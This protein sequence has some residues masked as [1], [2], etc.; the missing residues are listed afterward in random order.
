MKKV[1]TLIAASLCCASAL[2]QWSAPMPNKIQEM[3][4]DGT[5]QFLYNKGAGGFFTGGNEYGTRASI[6]AIGDSVRMTMITNTNYNFGDYPAT[7][8]AWYYLS[9]NNF[10]TMWIDAPN[11]SSNDTYPNTD[12]WNV[13]PQSDGSYKFVNNGYDANYTLGVAEIFNGKKGNTRLYIHD[14]EQTYVV[15]EEFKMSFEGNFYDT[16]Y[17][18]DE[19]EYLSLQP[20]VELYTTAIGLKN[21]IDNAK[22]EGIE[23]DFSKLEAVYNNTSSSIEEL[24]AA[25]ATTN[26]VV[27]FINTYNS[28][29]ASYPTANLSALKAICDNTASTAEEI[30]AAETMLL[31]E[32]LQQI[33]GN[34]TI[35]NP[36][37]FSATIGDG[38]TTSM[39][40]HSW[41]GVSTNGTWQTNTSSKEAVD[42]ADGTDMTPSFCELKIG[43]GSLVSDCF[44]TQELK[45]L[46]A[47][48]Y[49]FTADVRLYREAGKITAFKGAKMFF[50][51]DTIA[52]QD[53]SSVTYSGTKSILW[54]KDY[55]SVIAVVK[56]SGDITLGFDIQACNYNWFAFKNTT[57]QYYGNENIEKNALKLFKKSVNL[58]TLDEVDAQEDLISAYN[59]AVAEYNA[60]TTLQAAKKAVS[61]AST[62]MISVIENRNAYETLLDKFNT[63]EEYIGEKQDLVGDEWDAFCDFVQGTD[64]IEGYPT[65]NPTAIIEG[66][67]SLTTA[68]INDYIKK[69]DNLLAS[70]V[71]H[72]LLEGSDCTDMLTN[73]SFA[74][75]ITGWTNTGGTAGGL[76]AFPCVERYESTVDIYQVV[77][78]VSDGLYSI[79]CKAFERP[80]NNGEYD[81]ST[82]TNTCLFMNDLQTP[83]QNILADAIPTDKAVN[84]VNS[85]FEGSINEGYMDTS[86]TTNNDVEVIANGVASYIPNGMSGSSYAFRAGRYTQKVYGFVDGGEMKIGLTSNGKTAHWVLW[87]DFRLTYEGRSKEAIEGAIP[88]M[89]N[90][91]LAYIDD[92]IMTEPAQL[93]AAQAADVAKSAIGASTDDMYDALKDL[94]NAIKAA[95]Y[96]KEKTDEFNTL[97]DLMETS[98][99]TCEDEEARTAYETLLPEMGEWISLTTEGLESLYERMLAVYSKLIPATMEEAL[100]K[101]AVD[102]GIVTGTCFTAGAAGEITASDSKGYVKMRTGNNGNTITFTVNANYK[103]VGIN[104]EGYSNNNSTTADRSIDLIGLYIDGS[105]ESIIDEPFTFPGGTMGQTPA[106]FHKDGF[107]AKQQVVLKFDNSKINGEVDSKGKN[108]QIMA[109]VTFTYAINVGGSTEIRETTVNVTSDGAFYNLQGQ[110]IISPKRNTIYITNGKKLMMK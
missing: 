47:G 13:I 60:A 57:L 49:K 20:Q 54:N 73:A 16:W 44:I 85:F 15:G 102:K 74:N 17:F 87:S 80:A 1:L 65:P 34:A 94:N 109:K 5:P 75:G 40:T 67:R 89:A 46:P 98:Y 31:A 19:E 12:S 86:G 97:V 27:S 95:R 10:D 92:N 9:C 77:K 50:A 106:T 22:A 30:K 14:T 8:N 21:A 3:S 26:A 62:A 25:T 63:W 53:M 93:A 104:V 76:N 52:L 33:A 48:L 101:A 4:T 58:A 32:A 61:N 64:P 36:V 29:K 79:S 41:K 99:T 66:D 78:N 6:G 100:P 2:A 39:W 90:Q 11:A 38:S 28:V 68:E 51:N 35:D 56:E 59:A 105:E 23:H 81:E 110:R 91:L 84:Y 108:K 107:E 43:S 45:S 69:V 7:K 96:N 83:V 24:N 37:D 55:F 42:G 72:S 71:A 70:A 82:P 103:I 18:I 88:S